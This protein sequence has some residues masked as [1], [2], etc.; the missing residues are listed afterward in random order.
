M[1]A[2]IV[3]RHGFLQCQ[4]CVP[5]ILSHLDIEKQT[6]A[7]NPTGIDSKWRISEEAGRIQCEQNPDNVHMILEC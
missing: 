7:Q 3:I 6:N 1:S 2:L 5:K 4:V